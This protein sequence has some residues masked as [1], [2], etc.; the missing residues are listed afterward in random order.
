L[1][2]DQPGFDFLGFNMRQD[3]VGKHPA[4]KHSNGQ[5]LGL[6]TLS[7]P[8]QATS[9]AH[10]AELG[11]IMRRSTALPQGALSQPHNPTMRGWAHYYP[12]FKG[13]WYGAMNFALLPLL[14][15]RPDQCPR[16]HR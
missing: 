4:G 16:P 11:R 13:V 10:L 1:D 5:R 7:K 2:G 14:D 15:T 3:R 9:T 6:K 8:A 12:T